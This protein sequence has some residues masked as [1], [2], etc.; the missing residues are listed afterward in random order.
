M[1][2]AQSLLP[3]AGKFRKELD[4]NI[5][6]F[7]LKHALDR[8]FGGYFSCLDRDGSV[9]DDRKYLWLQGR[10]TWMFAR[11]WN[12]WAA[13]PEYLDAAKLGASFL[14]AHAFDA[15]GR[16]WFSLDR[17]GRPLFFQRKVY[18][19]VFVDLGLLEYS[20][21]A[22]DDGFRRA[23]TDLFW[24][25]HAWLENPALIDRPLLEGQIPMSNLAN[26]MVRAGLAI[27]FAQVDSDPRFREVLR[28]C[29]PAILRHYDPVHRV[30]RENVA[31]DGRSLAALPEGR[32]FNP[33]HSIEVAWFLLHL[34][35]FYPDDGA[36]K[37]AFDALEGSLEL[38]WDREYGGLFYFMDLEGKPLF[39]IEHAMKLWWPHT[40]AL[41]AL[42][43]ALLEE[44]PARWRAWF[45]K[46]VDYTWMH[47]PDP[48]YGHWFGYLDREGRVASA[49]K[50]N[51]YKGFFHT[52]RALMMSVQ[53]I[54]AAAR[55]MSSSP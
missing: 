24:R 7:W 6:P 54:E 42:V 48:E 43:L 32:L 14:R 35:E 38:G 41:Y 21:A 23:A 51:H 28:D 4:E 49:C 36:R 5:I 30:F 46:V 3:W 22:G 50:G 26:A 55:K 27:E 15:R 17:E 19:G 9:Y 45:E 40:E 31:L 2:A 53:R 13:K 12:Q 47:F 39:Q 52:P 16:V 10:F 20:L 1:T 34:L 29:I 25:I 11:L 44:G 18:P 8:E 33:G 37:T